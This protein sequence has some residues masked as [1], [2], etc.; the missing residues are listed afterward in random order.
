MYRLS[1]VVCVSLFFS[2]W[3]VVVPTTYF[4]VSEIQVLVDVF[5]AFLNLMFDK[6]IIVF[7]INMDD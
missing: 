5:E 6:I 1:I 7:T 3:L 2:P 4:V